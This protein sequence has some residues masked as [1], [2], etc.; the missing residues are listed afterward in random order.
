MEPVI[1]S[2]VRFRVRIREEERNPNVGAFCLAAMCKKS[3]E[4]SARYHNR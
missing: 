2:Q 3:W 4:T 1:D